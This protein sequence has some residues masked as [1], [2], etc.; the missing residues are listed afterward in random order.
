LILSPKRRRQ[1]QG[2]MIMVRVNLV[3]GRSA[4]LTYLAEIARAA[5][6]SMERIYRATFAP[7]YH[8]K[9]GR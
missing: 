5:R 3:S 8:A 2:S 7:A 9:I 6:K 1:S 4:R